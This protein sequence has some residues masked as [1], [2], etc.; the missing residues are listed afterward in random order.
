MST[1]AN[2]KSDKTD[3]IWF[4]QYHY[5]EA[6]AESRRTGKPLLLDFHS[7]DAPGT[8][9]LAQD[10]FTDRDVIAAVKATTVPVR[11]R[12]ETDNSNV[13]TS[14]LIGSHVFI[15]SASVQLVS[16]D[17]DIYHKFIGAPLFTRLD[18]GYNRVHCDSQGDLT[19]EDVLAQLELGLGKAKLFTDQPD[20]S[21]AYF[22]RVAATAAPDKPA[23]KEAVYWSAVSRNLTHAQPYPED[24]EKRDTKQHGSLAQAVERFCAALVQVPDTELMQDWKGSPG[25]GSWSKYS[26][27]LRE[28][29]F[30]IYQAV[31]D[32]GHAI[33]TLRGHE[34]L[35]QTNAQRILGTNQIAYRNLQ[36]IL[37]GLSG[38]DMD[39]IHLHE[40]GS[41]GKQRSIRNNYVH[42]VMAEWWAHAPQIRLALNQ[43][44]ESGNELQCFD[45]ICK[46]HGRQPMNFGP[47]AHLMEMSEHFHTLL[48]EEFQSITDEELVA[49]SQWWED[50]PITVDFR[51]NRLGWHLYD[52][53]AV[54]ETICE[55]IGRRRTETERL[56]QRMYVALG[57]TEGHAIGLPAGIWESKV[58]ALIQQLDTR[59]SELERH[60]VI[61]R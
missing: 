36:G 48:V 54:V 2:I 26:D 57:T 46:V 5:E 59:T 21:L 28:V 27:C 37:V 55:R 20:E 25:A 3:G 16:P 18:M 60:Y 30:G 44:R 51:L 40:N 33:E 9:R 50:T 10:I 38:R 49:C 42:C 15:C 24:L 22:E 34:K 31:V 1:T 8:V 47:I 43:I 61:K 6:L 45:D 58:N 17:G 19:K 23:C 4:D 35:Y 12:V 53:A 39:R 11:I 13:P 32:L 56:A 41:L 29:F 14:R 7:K 52:H